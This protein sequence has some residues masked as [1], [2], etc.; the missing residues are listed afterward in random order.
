VPSLVRHADD[1]VAF[2]A[3]PPLAGRWPRYARAP[4]WTHRSPSRQVLVPETTFTVE[5]GVADLVSSRILQP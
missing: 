4:R 3:A 1:A 5:D 2:A